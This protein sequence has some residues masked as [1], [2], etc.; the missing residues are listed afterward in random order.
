[1]E[2]DSMRRTSAFLAGCG[3]ALTLS[4]AFAQPTMAVEGRLLLPDGAPAPAVQISVVGRS[5]SVLT[6]ED[7][8]FSLLPTPT[9]PF[10]LIAT[11]A[12]GDVF[13]PIEVNELPAASGQL[14]V[15][16]IEMFQDALTVVSGVA[17]SVETLPASAAT[18]LTR[19][20][21]EQR[22][23]QRIVDALAGL[24]GMSQTG[25]S[26]DS[27]PVIRGLGSGRTLI[28]LD[29]ARVTSER[30]A[31]A[32]A[33]FVDAAAL[34]SLEVTR[35]PGAV[36]YGSDAF[37]GVI[38][39]RPRDAEKGP[40]QV[41]F[42]LGG[43]FEGVDESH[44]Y[45]EATGKVGPG[46]LLFS[47]RGREA[48]D[49]EAGDGERVLNSSFEDRGASL[50]YLQEVG[51]GTLRLGVQWDEAT[52]LGKPASDSALIRAFYPEEESRRLTASY[53]VG[54][55]GGWEGLSASLFYG[56]YHL[57]T[58]RD[59]APT[60]TSNR[61]IDRSDIDSD[62]ASLR[63]EANRN[64][65]GGRL[66]LGLDANSRFNLRALTGRVDFNAAGVET[67][68]T[69]VVSI[70][71]A[72]RL[73]TGLFAIYDRALGDRLS[74]SVGVRGDRIESENQGGFFGDR[75]TTDSNVAGHL[76]LTADLG[77][78]FSATLQAARG[79]RSPLLSDRYFRGPSGRGFITGNPELEPETSL[80]YDG[81]LRWARGRS[82][83]GFY[84]YL[85]R[86]DDLIERF[87]QGDDFFF[88][89]RGEAEIKGLEL[90]GQIG[91]AGGF[92]LQAGATWAE[93]EDRASGDFIDSIPTLSGFAAL[94]FSRERY[95]AFTR[96]N[97]VGEDDRPGP[98]EDARPG[99]ATFDLGGGWHV[100][101][102]LELRVALDNV[103]DKRYRESADDV[104]PL[105]PGRTVRVAITGRL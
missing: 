82:A 28:L 104:S 44:G 61:R 25:K 67:R 75:S 105:A 58:D 32:S 90:E 23:P 39:A 88:R 29:G 57:I 16:L 12:R 89:N 8:T 43:G 102:I 76:A 10:V 51:A 83:V 24:P 59:R 100:N 40:W 79:F 34:G 50:R 70:D 36:A 38:D 14:E 56:T 5:G 48:E 4:L 63:F 17:A 27:V 13:A 78:G 85:Y 99:Y 26:A 62:D 103:T 69:E 66:K 72:N 95:Y 46:A 2:I 1:M 73:A 49:S 101:R 92:E 87:R 20:D 11:S 55:I 31:G 35:G 64:L 7:G 98:T 97:G 74:L 86:I 6:A 22:R 3:L 45:V 42:D 30:R 21:L 81:A 54:S 41:R 77:Q 18:T 93:G 65:G 52:D 60:S 71:E 68:R 19:E 53:R 91:L 84:A 9:P 15:Q 37:G 94:R 80:Q 96:V 33:T 47:A